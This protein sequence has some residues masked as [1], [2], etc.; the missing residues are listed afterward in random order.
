[1]TKP[2]TEDLKKLLQLD[3]RAEAERIGTDQW[4]TVYSNHHGPDGNGGYF[5]ALVP[6]E[7]AAK[8]MGRDTW[9][10]S[11]GNG[12]PGF[13]Q[14]YGG[15]KPIT[16]YHRFGG[17]DGVEPLVLVRSF[18]G[19]KPDYIELSEEFRHLLN[20][21]YDRSNDRYLRFNDNGDEEVVAEVTR[22][23]VRIK[24]RP[25]R[26]FLA[27]RQMRLAVY[28]DSVAYSSA[29]VDVDG[30][31]PKQREQY[32]VRSDL[33]Y[34]FH[35]GDRALSDRPFSRILGK[36]LVDPVPIEEC[37]IWPYEEKAKPH[38]EF[39]IGLDKDGKEVSHSSDPEKLANYLGKNAGAP[40]F[41]TP[42]VFR[43][44]VLKKYF[45]HPEK[46]E[47]SDGYLRCAGLWGLHIDNHSEDRVTVFLGDLG[48]TLSHEEQLYW[49]SFN[50]APLGDGKDL[51]DTTK[52]RAFLER[53]SV[54][55]VAISIACA[56]GST[57]DRRCDLLAPR[58]TGVSAR[59]SGDDSLESKCL[60]VATRA[61]SG[62]ADDANGQAVRIFAH[63]PT[64]A[65]R[66]QLPGGARGDVPLVG[67]RQ[68]ARGPGVARH[69]RAAAGVHGCVRRAG[70]GA[71][72]R[73]R[74]L[75]DGPGG[76]RSG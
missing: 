9:E 24:T 66:R 62:G 18:H 70:R 7:H 42:V 20:L 52:R 1:M 12:L 35:I 30:I 27:A 74:P 39:I 63:A 17:E 26:Q 76:A 68:A 38:V 41:L 73:R 58:G 28:F 37:G 2:S 72:G 55:S 33:R 14:Q 59:R 67:R 40:H 4:L 45:D 16:K 6:E 53:R 44:E 34:S 64:R 54:H 60:A 8:V 65:F 15:K 13:S 5:C 75:A 50:I 51:S 3:F 71:G 29:D 23:R 31:D 57:R 11:I 47:I 22:D 46:Y 48:Q 49:R 69:G 21:Y 19:V 61:I 10:L 56:R 43:R 32:V 25:L 36:R